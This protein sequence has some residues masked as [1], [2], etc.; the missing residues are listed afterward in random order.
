MFGVV[1]MKTADMERFRLAVDE[2][3]REKRALESM[4]SH[5]WFSGFYLRYTNTDTLCL[6][7]D[8]TRDYAFPGIGVSIFPLRT[9]AASVK[10]ERRLSR[11]ENAWTELC[12][13]NYADRN[14]RSR[15]NR[16]IM[17]LQCM[18]TGRQ[19]QAAHLY[20]RLVRSC[21]QPGANK[22]ILKRRKQTTIFPAE[23]FAESKR[24]TLEGAELQVPV[25]TAEYLTISY[26]KNYKDAKEPRYV[27]PIAL[28]VSARVSYTQFWKE[29]GNFEKYCKERM[30]NARKL[31]RS[32]RHKDYFNECW[33][34]VEFCG[35]RMNLGVSYE[36]QKD[37][38]KNLY[39]N[40]DYMT[41]D[42][43]F[44]PYFKMMQKSLQKNEL[45]AE[46]EEIFDIYID[47]LEKT[48]KTVQRSKIGT[49]I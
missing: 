6:N 9:P 41:L 35:E 22:Y 49:L 16:T 45:F 37:Y 27:T 25:K 3:P 15:V 11:D 18:I 14:F 10:A 2:D 20:D 26:G 47:V 28:A 39:K 7:L 17:R 36:K 29:S 33:D 4:K 42:K 1:L 24:V 46:D 23:I 5:K 19:G 43:V 8:N 32:R 30:K 31:A 12:H 44:R 48:G 40:E 34:Y 21:Q 38:I 13:I